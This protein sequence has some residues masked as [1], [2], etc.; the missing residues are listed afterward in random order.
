MSLACLDSAGVTG[1]PPVDVV[2]GGVQKAALAPVGADL[3]SAGRGWGCQMG[4]EMGGRTTGMGWPVACRC[5]TGNAGSCKLAGLAGSGTEKQHP[6][7][8]N[9][10]RFDWPIDSLSHARHGHVML[11]LPTLR[12]GRVVACWTRTVAVSTQARRRPL[13]ALAGAAANQTVPGPASRRPPATQ[14]AHQPQQI[15]AVMTQP[16]FA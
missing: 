10:D 6:V 5:S 13:V 14:D 12:S 11:A 16:L 9:G 7:D 1:L 2:V 8:D 3:T 4:M 15:L